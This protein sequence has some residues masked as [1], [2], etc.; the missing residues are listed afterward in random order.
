MDVEALSKENIYILYVF[1][2]VF[3]Y[4]YKAII[5]CVKIPKVIWTEE[6][7]NIYCISQ[8]IHIPH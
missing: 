6:P 2:F 4:N 5:G 3:V 8:Q 7:L 1:I